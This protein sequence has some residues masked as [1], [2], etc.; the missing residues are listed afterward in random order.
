[1]GITRRGVAL[2]LALLLVAGCDRGPEGTAAGEWRYWGGDAGS[3]RYS[4]LDQIGSDNIDDLEIAWRWS[5]REFGPRPEFYFRATPLMANGTLYTVAGERREV[6][7]IDPGTGE[8]LWTWGMDEGER[9]ERAPRRFS[10]RG[11]TWW[12]DGAHERI[13]VTTP[14]YRLVA[15]DA[16][17]GHPVAGFGRDGVVDLQENLGYEVDPERGIDPAE[18]S[19]GSSSPPIVAHG[20][21]VVGAAH[22]PGT[23]PRSMRNIPGHVRGYDARSGELLWTF[24][25]IPRPGEYGHETWENEAWLY[26]GNVGIW[27][28]MSVDEELGIV[29]LPS[30]AGTNDYYGGHR[31]GDNV[32]ATSLIA[33]DVRTGERVWHQQ[34]IRHDLWDWDL[35]TAPALVDIVVDGRPVQAVAQV[36]KQAFVYMFD[37]ATGEPVWPMEDRPVPQTDVPGERTS[38]T[39]PFP[40]RPAPF[41]GQGVVEAD[42]ID[43]TPELREE[44]LELVQPY[45]LGPLFLPPSLADAPDGTRGALIAP[46]A[47]GGA[48]I[49]G[50]AAVDAETGVLYVASI[51]GHSLIALERDTVRSDMDFVSRGAAGLRGPQGLPLLRPPWGRITAIDLN[52]GDHLWWVPNGETPEAVRGHPALEGVALPPTGKPVHANLLVTRTL[53]FAG[54]GRGGSAVFRAYDKASGRILR[55]LELPAPTNAAPMTYMHEGRQY[56]VVAVSD[57]QNGPELVALAL[58]R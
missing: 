42:L 14:G 53:L 12:S 18:G 57:A 6:A 17:T 50:G 40:T 48:N 22:E 43:F 56:I 30:S 25:T 37:R 8:T 41:D 2:A 1:M 3:T 11:L 21:I 54:E 19:I 55:E 45:R 52:T 46:G 5:A 23:R 49:M 44:A 15:L 34:L 26:T 16:A 27:P 9:F 47:F 58:P 7:A 31:L 29:Y 36:T 38:P 20:V 4:A 10:G 13:F 35:P 24:H 33:L 28:P 39:Q 32:F 51:R